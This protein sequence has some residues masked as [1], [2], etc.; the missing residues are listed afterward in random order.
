MKTDDD[1]YDVPDYV[2]A[3][4]AVSC[5]YFQSSTEYSS[6]SDYQ[7][8]LKVLVSIRAGYNGI[9]SSASFTASSDY[10]DNSQIIEN[11]NQFIIEAGASC[12]VYD[13]QLPVN[14]LRLIL[15][16]NFINT[17]NLAYTGQSTWQ[18]VIDTFGTHLVVEANLGGRNY[19]KYSMTAKDKAIL[20][21]SN[22]DVSAAASFSYMSFTGSTSVSVKNN[23]NKIN[24]FNSV[25]KNTRQSIIGGSPITNGDIIGWQK[26][27]RQSPMPI[28]YSLVKLSDL[29][30]QP[31]FPS[32]TN[33]V[34]MNMQK[35][36]SNAIDNYCSINSNECK[37]PSTN[38]IPELQ[39][40][41]KFYFSSQIGGQGGGPFNDNIQG[42][43]MFNPNMQIVKIEI[44][45]GWYIDSLQ[46]FLS[47][48][49]NSFALNRH[50]G[51]GGKN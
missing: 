22:I 29:I 27:V 3:N 21:S 10:S 14:D 15:S 48:S 43:Y 17:L 36:L 34:L 18:S 45:S 20:K 33:S 7:Q 2:T 6:S 38:N 46:F 9:L 5:E 26:T 24:K 11:S 44:R 51:D 30:D 32:L 47:D 40:L 13:L 49:Q 23:Q 42:H 41:L 35:S 16:Q 28:S 37:T 8:S 12:Q 1:M 31:H 25:V 39:S 4:N 50:G 19:F